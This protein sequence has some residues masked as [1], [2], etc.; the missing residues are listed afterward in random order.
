M[1]F[2]RF[3]RV[4]AF[5]IALALIIATPV[6]EQASFA[7]ATT[8]S[9]A[10]QG[11]VTDPK[12]AVLPGVTVTITNMGT[13]S[14]KRVTTDSAGF[15][16]AASLPPAQYRISTEVSG[17]SKTSTTVVVQIGNSTN[18]DLKLQVGNT[19]E[20]VEVNAGALEVNTVQ[21]TVQGVLTEK[22]IETLPISGRNFL[23]LAQL[24][25]GVQLQ[26]GETFDPTKAGY[27]SIAINGVNG[28]TARILLD[29]QDI[30]DETV[31]TT[32][33][34]VSQGSIQE[35]Q[36]SRSS[37]D[38]SNELTSSGSVTV[39]TRSGTNDLHGQAFGLFRD[40][41]AGAAEG[42]GGTDFPFQR[43]QFGG[44][45]GGPIVKNKL[46]FFGS[47][48][49]VK[50][51]SFNSVQI[52]APF[53]ALSGGFTAP[54]RDTY[55]AAKLDYNA[56]KN[57]HMFF[58]TAYENNLDDSA[59]G[60]GFS[61][62][63]N[64]DNT[65]SFA[66]GADFSMGK[67][68]NSLRV[69]YLKFHNLIVDETGSGVPNPVPGVFL[70]VNNNLFTGPNEL[71]PQQTF[72]SD[73]QF[74]YDAGLTV[75]SHVFNFG[76]SMN[77]ILGGG[78]ASFFGL[79]PRVTAN[80]QAGPV[81]GGLASDPTAYSASQVVLG[82]GQG[83]NTERAQF[84]FP[85][86]GQEDWRLGV[87]F[88][89]TWKVS[90]R[91]TLNYGVRY[92]R[93]TGRSDSDLAPIP[94][95]D[96]VASFGTDSPCTTGNLLDALQPIQPFA[97][98]ITA[99]TGLGNKVRQP[100]SNWGPKFGF[101]YDLKGDGKT[102]LRGGL[103]LY[104]ENSIFNNV[105]F[106]RSSRL[107]SGLFFGDAA[108]T[109]GEASFTLPDG[110]IVTSVNGQTLPALFAEPISASGA[111]F[112]ALQALY[113]AATIKAG[114]S[115]NSNYV[116]NSLAEGPDVNG[117][118]LYAP[119]YKTARSVQMNI[120]VEHEMWKG[121]IFAADYL[122]NV[123]THF[124]QQIDGNHVGDARFLN[125]VAANN[126]IALTLAH[127]HAAT[128]DQAIAAGAQ[129][130]DFAGNG[131]DSGIGFLGGIP[132]SAAG[133]TPSTGAAFAGMNPAFGEMFIVSPIGRS[134]F[135]AFQTSFR[136][137]SRIPLRGLKGSS[138]QISYSLSRFI[139]SAG[140]S[141]TAGPSDQNFTP[142]VWDSNN[143]LGFSGPAG[144]D[145]KHQLS[146]G[147]SFNWVG[148]FST[149][150][151][152]H[153]Y[154]ALPTDLFLDDGGNSSGE[155]FSSDL[156]GD[157]TVKDLLPGF[158]SGALNRSVK[159]GDLGRVIANYN[160]TSAGK[161]T[162]A[163][164]ALVSAGLFTSTQ[165]TQLGAV[166]RS[167][168]APPTGNVGNGSLRTFDLALARPIKF[169]ERMSLEPSFSVFNLFN[170]ANFGSVL[171]NLFSAQ[172]PGTANGTDSSLASR[173]ALRT[174]NGSGV[175][176]LGAARIIEYG[177]KFNF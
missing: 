87:Y 30:S 127:F 153:Y 125:G 57:V 120:G 168:A 105:L 60:F 140:G 141:G 25:P 12:G 6:F 48:E 8:A 4:L 107:K 47:G 74:R 144:T 22:Q 170:F 121:G 132:A 171:G 154:S 160:A 123:G 109:P 162:P 175:F 166:T 128:I 90:R 16:S 20:V 172:Q 72:Q 148:G 54:F 50:Q 156:T 11:T 84:G 19:T 124:M 37:L 99:P 113:Q 71:A 174:G 49:R 147:G 163:G 135:N 126:A 93:D 108:V 111:S 146:I 157:G 27:S 28:R 45:V 145:R 59:F 106:D 151:I 10:I 66:G 44:R 176:S 68:T 14:T 52:L 62:F 97:Q 61:R 75:K 2:V 36:V 70:R 138:F 38:L 31:G 1:R 177:L 41:R 56:P 104:Y 92:S 42:P 88:G 86:G 63:G 161:I 91:L 9:G 64:K 89:D 150:F 69:S 3:N 103:G 85:A 7:Q 143:P 17:F 94:C 23:D 129:M 80:F 122:R 55:Y 130:S 73:K 5:G 35:F 67:L 102:V 142:G 21:S 137:S 152:G 77:R 149:S 32:T 79:A 139:S 65:P 40:Q 83:F 100:N 46:F 119:N 95:S 101:A 78:F 117:Q 39:S 33:L 131:L 58:R 112:A 29:G 81:G 158:K 115:T 53:Q 133:L 155:I 116:G 167:I 169:T 82:N 43:N 24:E 165:L 118:Y 173:G 76:V 110:T 98:L 18:G 51:D 15:Y 13:N 134:V 96:A 159:P 26:S 164:Q 136:Q 34:N 114:A